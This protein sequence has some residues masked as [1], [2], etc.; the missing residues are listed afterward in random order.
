MIVVTLKVDEVEAL[1]AYV[2][3]VL[4]RWPLKDS[5]PLVRAHDKLDNAL[6]AHEERPRARGHLGQ[7]PRRQHA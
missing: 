2:E 7:Q 3:P 4:D 6:L 5:E 1:L